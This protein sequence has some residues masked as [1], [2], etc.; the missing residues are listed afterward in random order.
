[1]SFQQGLSGLNAASK[2]L[3]A[4]GNN[5]A[6]ANTV[7]FKQSQAHFADV[8]ASSLAGS[9]DNTIGIGT[10]VLGV[11]QQFTQGNISVT[12]NPLDMAVNGGGFF[13]MSEN[14]TITYTRNG[15]FHLD[16]FGFI[17]DDTQR[18]LTGFAADASGNI[19]PT[20]PTD[21][22]LLTSDQP[23]QVT[24]NFEAVLNLDAGA[25]IPATQTR[26]ALTGTA[27]AI[28]FP[29]TI[30][31]ATNDTLN[32][33]LNGTAGTATVAPGVY[34]TAAALATAVQTAINA[35]PAFAAAG[36][37]ATVTANANVLTITSDLYGNGSSM[38]VTGGSA[39]NS[40]RLNTFTATAGSDNFSV[41]DPTSFTSSTSG[42]VYDS[43]G[44]PHVLTLYFVKTA[45]VNGWRIYSNVDGTAI[46][47]VNLGAGAGLPNS[48]A[49]NTA[50]TLTT[51]MPLN[52]SVDLNAVATALG[53]TNGATT[54]LAFALDFA[55]TTQ[56][57]SPFG[58]NSLSQDGFASGRLSG[59]SAGSDG[60]ILGRYTNG[61]T[62][63]MGQVVL[64]NFNNPNGLKPLGGNQWSETSNSG[65][66]Q[67]GAP[68]TASLGFLQAAAVEESN[69][70][71][72][73]ELVNMITLQ[74]V[75]Q[76]NAQT[77][78]TQDAVLQTLVNLR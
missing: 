4:T 23:P 37:T 74:R 61:Q 21:L 64:V 34:A 51:A 11:A 38:N 18:R 19:V 59:L 9:G 33:T 49:F 60:V 15:Q 69:V 52:V 35:V 71:L 28:T 68:G 65:L 73:A 78:K 16:Q 58:V 26:A 17:V 44:N 20:A 12:N 32:V 50:G 57:G 36:Y 40:L 76:A 27:G 5:V 30:T 53:K 66:P 72:T 22:Q 62:R 6:N 25:A 42:T 39:Q 43:L 2:A 54:P 41:T 55:G 48:I 1:M 8:Y 56:F 14:G 75:Y 31:A 46:G 7:G 70:D 10:Q 67:V 45:A 77:I 24:T 3:D 47:N 29:L 13:R 63:A